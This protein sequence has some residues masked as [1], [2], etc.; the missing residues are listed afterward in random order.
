MGVVLGDQLQVIPADIKQRPQFLA[1]VDGD[2]DIYKIADEKELIPF[3][4]KRSKEG[5]VSVYELSDSKDE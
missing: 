5:D 4:E 1:I 3:L 2:N